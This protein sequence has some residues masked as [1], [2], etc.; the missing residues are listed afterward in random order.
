MKNANRVVSQ[1]YVLK[2]LKIFNMQSMIF[3]DCLILF[4]RVRELIRTN[5]R[6]KTLKGLPF[7]F[8]SITLIILNPL[9]RFKNVY[10]TEMHTIDN[11]NERL[12]VIIQYSR[13]FGNSTI[14]F[15]IIKP[16]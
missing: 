9:K 3:K 15:I 16:L 14:K 2:R 7:L 6:I 5:W 11:R 8:R 10:D 1:R 4:V 12:S 13:K